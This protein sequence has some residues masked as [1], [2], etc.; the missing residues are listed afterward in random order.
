MSIRHTIY[1]YAIDAIGCMNQGKNEIALDLVIQIATL[2]EYQTKE[3]VDFK[4]IVKSVAEITGISYTEI[5]ERNRKK[6]VKDARHL[7]VY[8][9]KL[10]TSHKLKTIGHLFG[11]RDHATV[12]HSIDTINDYLTYDKEIQKQVSDIR[13]TLEYYTTIEQA[14][15]STPW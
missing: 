3:A 15:K 8:F 1:Q 14:N 5:I 9:T 11:G 10:Y 4:T 6:E 13:K 2:T 7:A 12:L